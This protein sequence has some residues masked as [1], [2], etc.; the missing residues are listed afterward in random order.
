MDVT[1]EYAKRVLN[2]EASKKSISIEKVAQ[3]TAE[4]YNVTVADFKSASRNQRVSSARHVAVYLAREITEKSFETI[5]EY[6]NKKHTTM[7]Y[8][9]EKIKEDLKIN[10]DLDRAIAEIKNKL[11]D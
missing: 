8:S 4:Y 1:L 7:L 2:C 3:L 5:A 10:K 6:F 11:K 9:Y